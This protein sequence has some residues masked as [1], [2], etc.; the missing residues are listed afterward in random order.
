MARSQSSLS[1]LGR[2]SATVAS[3][4]VE[5]NVHYIK[6][7]KE[8][9]TRIVYLFTSYL[10][11]RFSFL[12]PSPQQLLSLLSPSN[13]LAPNQSIGQSIKQLKKKKKKKKGGN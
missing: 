6:T 12:G 13:L 8:Q 5:A 2:F 3:H 10:S 1:V 4:W 9:K 11:N 7:E